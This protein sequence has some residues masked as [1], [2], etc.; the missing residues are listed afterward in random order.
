MSKVPTFIFSL[1]DNLEASCKKHN[2]LHPKEQLS[3]TDFLPTQANPTDTGYDVRCAEPNG[4]ALK[5]GVYKLINLGFN[6]CCPEGWWL[7][8][9]PRSSTFAKK[10]CH[11]LY[12][13]IDESYP[14]NVKFAVQ[15]LPDSSVLLKNEL[16]ISF[17]EKI[18]QII[19]VKRETMEVKLAT[20]EE[21]KR[22]HSLKASGRVG[23]FGSTGN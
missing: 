11:A 23:G 1:D 20:R 22:L 8:L 9:V 14:D 13:T 2:S 16:S 4:V 19:P 18:G 17:G 12:G 6:V 15:Y 21:V 5:P 3:V 7:K 10:H